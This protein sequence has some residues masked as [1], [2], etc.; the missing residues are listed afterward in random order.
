[1]NINELALKLYNES[2][3]FKMKQRELDADY[4]I[5]F[6]EINPIIQEQWKNLAA[7]MIVNRTEVYRASDTISTGASS[8]EHKAVHSTG[9]V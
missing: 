1:M 5:R 4:N 3:R 7:W 6:G 8:T 9:Q 2:V